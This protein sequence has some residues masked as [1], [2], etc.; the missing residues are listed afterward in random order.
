MAVLEANH[1]REEEARLKQDAGII[2][3]AESLKQHGQVEQFLA[4]SDAMMRTY[5]EAQRR[6]ID[7]QSIG[8]PHRALRALLTD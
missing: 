2:A 6:G 7:F 3:M 8:G 4:D 5:H 1:Y